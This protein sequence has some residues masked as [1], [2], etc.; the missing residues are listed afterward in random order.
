MQTRPDRGPAVA[1]LPRHHIPDTVCLA[2]VQLNGAAPRFLPTPSL[3]MALFSDTIFIVS[4]VGGDGFCF[5]FL[6]FGPKDPCLEAGTGGPH[7]SL[8]SLRSCPR[9][10]GGEAW[11]S[12]FPLKLSFTSSHLTQLSFPLYLGNHYALLVNKPQ[13]RF[14]R[15]LTWSCLS[16]RACPV[17]V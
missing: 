3:Q 17:S 7:C 4:A 11:I 9:L 14:P 2:A 16:S 15:A 13:G 5:V 12:P 1:Y 10:L 8:L 6:F